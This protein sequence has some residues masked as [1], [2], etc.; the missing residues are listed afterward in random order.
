MNTQTPNP[1]TELD[2]FQRFIA[3]R[4]GGTL[5]GHTLGEA[6]EE[7]RLYR[8]QLSELRTKLEKSAASGTLKL[9]D[10][11]LEERFQQLDKELADEGIKD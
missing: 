1:Q 6:V 5:N 8:A 2:E 11:F 4:H 3:E 7:F 9:T 10:A